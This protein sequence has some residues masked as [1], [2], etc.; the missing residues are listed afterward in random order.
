MTREEL[1]HEIAVGL[2]ET[3]IEGEYGTITKSTAYDCPSLGISQ[4]E[5]TRAD[6]LLYKLDLGMYAG[7]SYSYLNNI[8]KLNYISEVLDSDL[9]REVQLNLLEEDCLVYVDTLSNIHYLDWGRCTIYAG[10]W[11][12]TSHYVVSEFLA[13]K[14][15]EGYV[16]SNL[17]TLRDLFYDYYADYANIPYNCYAGYRNRAINTYNYTR[18]L[19]LNGTNIKSSNKN[20]VNKMITTTFKCFLNPGHSV[21]EPSWINPEPDHGT[22]SPYTGEVEAY[23]AKE[24]TEAVNKY[25]IAAGITTKVFQYDGL[26]EISSTSNKWNPDIFV[27]IH[28]NSAGSS[29]A[30][31]TETFHYYGSKNGKK[32]AECIHKQILNK[33][34]T[35]EYCDKVYA[36]TGIDCDRGVKEANYHVL[37]ETDCTAVLVEMAFMSNEADSII[38]RDRKDD[39][40]RAIAVGITDYQLMINKG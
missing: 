2:I 21:D 19:N 27:S 9:G 6:T 17:E 33:I 4:W 37:R 23:V 14:Q 8:N 7:L 20:E 3:G 22:S 36:E 13:Q 5:G 34:F 40:A 32:L 26:G 35:K 31:G 25:L 16:I 29:K 1:A 11:C 18:S 38:L 10:M 12:P 24:V 39:F 30:R 28:C 15:R